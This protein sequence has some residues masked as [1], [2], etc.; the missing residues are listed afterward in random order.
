VK[1]DTRKA[2]APYALPPTELAAE[3][4][5]DASAGRI[6]AHQAADR[7]GVGYR[8]DDAIHLL[9]QAGL[10]PLPSAENAAELANL[11]RFFG[12]A[13]KRPQNP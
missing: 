3:L 6:C 9:R 5:R 12:P 7:L 8:V 13:A 10:P 1:T 2:V 11:L 4:I